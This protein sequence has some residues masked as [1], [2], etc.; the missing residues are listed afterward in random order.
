MYIAHWNLLELK[1]AV[2]QQLCRMMLAVR[3]LHLIWCKAALHAAVHRC[4]R[5]WPAFMC[6]ANW[7]GS[8]LLVFTSS[9]HLKLARTLARQ[10]SHCALLPAH[11][12]LL[13]PK[14]QSFAGEQ[15]M[16]HSLLP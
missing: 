12:A 14:L 2:S 10:T 16:A 11:V 5:D 6:K 4:G 15:P 9:A 13:L 7:L 8:R 3:V 1:V